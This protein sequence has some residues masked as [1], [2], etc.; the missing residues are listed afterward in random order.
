MSDSLVSAGKE[1]SS[2]LMV[3]T[4]RHRSNEEMVR[5]IESSGAQIITMAIGRLDLD[6][7]AVISAIA[8]RPD[9]E[10][11]TSF[12]VDQMRR[13]LEVSRAATR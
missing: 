12:L 13:A 8:G 4:G 7:P 10:A 2:R 1:F 9:P 3:G 6:N 11:A 5:S